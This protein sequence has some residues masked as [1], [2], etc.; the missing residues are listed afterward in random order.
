VGGH[1][2]QGNGADGAANATS[3]AITDSGALAQAQ[4]TAVG[5]SGE[6]QS[7]A[8][9]SF[10]RVSLVQSIATAQAG[11]TA[12][13]SATAQAGGSGRSFANPGQTAYAIATGLPGKAYLQTLVVGAGNVATALLGPHD[14]AFGTA[15]L[16]ANYAP[17][18]GG[19]SHTYSAD[20]TFD[21]GYHGDLV[22]GLIDNQQNGFIG[23]LGFQTMEF[24]VDANGKD[25]FDVTL[26][27]LAVAESFFRDNVLNL[28]LYS[29]PSVDLT[30]GYNLTADGSGGFGLDVAVGGAAPEAS[31]WAMMLI[32]FAGLGFVGYRRNRGSN[33]SGGVKQGAE[34]PLAAARYQNSNRASHRS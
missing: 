11:S 21:I 29:G 23:G 15:V 1:G 13:T 7:T 10:G 3:S 32:G 2:G 24:Y 14:V 9:T 12:T 17:D 28:G 31:T 19:E 34:A 30:F 5:S 26:G 25:I 22:L 6:A 16:G 33:R 27:N 8:Q 18:G 20:S 4:S